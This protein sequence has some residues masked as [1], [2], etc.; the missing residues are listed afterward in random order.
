MSRIVIAVES[1]LHCGSKVGICPP[2]PIEIDDGDQY[3]PSKAQRWLWDKRKAFLNRVEEVRGNDEL[4]YVC[5]GD[6]VDGDHHNTHQIISRQGH[7]QSDIAFRCL[8][9]VLAL[10]PDHMF[11]V[12]GTESHVGKGGSSE[13][14]IARG[15]SHGGAP[16][17]KDAERSS[18]SWYFLRMHAGSHLLEFT[19]HG[20]TGYRPWT[21]P[22]ATLLLAAQIF[23]ERYREDPSLIPALSV[24]SHFHRYADSHDAHPVRVV[25]TPAFQL[26]TAYIWKRHPEGLADIGGII[27][28]IEDDRLTVEPVIFRPSRPK[29]WTP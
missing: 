11:V 25:Q 1:D 13:E 15:L 23:H 7:V 18:A 5:N 16:I 19:H 6:L 21:R 2:T 20:R 9:E 22:N 26:G 24:R 17:R 10:E 4:R 27:V 28:V 3:I 12:R 8:D 29:V 14:A